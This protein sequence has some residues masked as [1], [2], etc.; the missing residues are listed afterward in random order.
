[1]DSV[2]ARS[3]PGR[4]LPATGQEAGL[5]GGR[6]VPH[7]PPQLPRSCI[8][9][10]A[11]LG[12]TGAAQLRWPCQHQ[13]RVR[14]LRGPAR[15]RDGHRPCV[16]AMSPSSSA[17]EAGARLNTCSY[18]AAHALLRENQWMFQPLLTGTSSTG[19][20]RRRFSAREASSLTSRPRGPWG[21]APSLAQECCDSAS[22]PPAPA[23][24]T[25]ERL[26]LTGAAGKGRAARAGTLPT[27]GPPPHLPPRGQRHGQE[28]F[29]RG[30]KTS[31]GPSLSCSCFPFSPK[32]R[33]CYFSDI[34]VTSKSKHWK[35]IST[36]TFPK[37]C[38]DGTL[39][40]DKQGNTSQ[41]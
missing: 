31:R 28:A 4:G 24:K 9:K 8:R 41:L 35:H 16:P 34:T 25:S 14:L 7:T 38:T 5:T 13:D 33:A 32:L 3:S 12:Q 39:H 30:P 1:M 19:D 17:A 23:P 15:G 20:G 18:Y 36:E 21:P 37:R 10:A 27:T 29:G 22:L 40:G 6:P 26:I 2:I 11:A